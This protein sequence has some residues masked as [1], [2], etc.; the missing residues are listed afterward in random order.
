MKWLNIMGNQVSFCGKD[1]ED[2][3]DH[4]VPLKPGGRYR[5][6]YFFIRR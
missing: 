6:F 2:D 1:L 3:C 5:F 4:G